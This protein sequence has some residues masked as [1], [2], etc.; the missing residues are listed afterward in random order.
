VLE[1]TEHG[2]M[3]SDVYQK[4]SNDRILFIF[5]NINDNLATDITATLLLKDY[6]NPEQKITLFI[7]SD[8]G[9]IRNVFMIYDI[10]QMISAPVET[11]CLGAA[12]GE[13]ALL[14]AGGTP[15]MRLATKNSIISV[16]LLEPNSGYH[17]DMV[18]AKKY[19]NMLEEDNKR[20]MNIY[21]KATKKPL[22][23]IIK[24]FD[25]RVFMD[26]NKAMKYGLI[27]KIIKFNK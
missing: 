3:P 22:K 4:L 27:D 24:D 8:G 11:V 18:D 5:G 1:E 25:R 2:D 12:M 9:N 14:L 13:S 7:N 6:E 26:S 16:S 20:M 21:A 10:M 17:V 23:Q 19:M 15:G